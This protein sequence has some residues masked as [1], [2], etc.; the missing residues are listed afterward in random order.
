MEITN[1]DVKVLGRV[2]SITT[3]GIVA[4]AEQLYDETYKEGMFQ[5]DINRAV[6][7]DITEINTWISEVQPIQNSTIDEICK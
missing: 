5:D 2:A 6:D 1:N 4:S 7:G 3:D